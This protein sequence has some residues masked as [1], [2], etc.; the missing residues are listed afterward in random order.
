MKSAEKPMDKPKDESFQELIVTEHDTFTQ[1]SQYLGEDRV[2]RTDAYLV[3][4]ERSA[5]LYDT[6]AFHCG[7]YQAVMDRIGEMPLTVL[8]SHG[9]YDHAGEALNDFLRAGVPAYMSH[10]DKTALYRMY[11]AGY[12]LEDF[13]PLREGMTFDLGGRVL[14]TMTVSG[15]SPGS[16]VLIDRAA[17]IVY[18]ADAIGA[19]EF[20]MSNGYEETSLERTL[21][22]TSTLLA[23]METMKAPQIWTGHSN[24]VPCG[25]H[26]RGY[27]E[28]LVR[29]LADLVEGRVEGERYMRT[30]EPLYTTRKYDRNQ[31]HLLYN[32]HRI[33]ERSQTRNERT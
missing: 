4:G 31:V 16:T 13:L 8:I 29:V 11:G 25:Y 22:E 10:A 5:L 2:W 33:W 32:D 30:G 19:Y 21:R 20:Q 15:H 28:E 26:G 17:D 3:V 12:F 24:M 1:F 6:L 27:L 23:V 7:L 9:H 14:K 18:T